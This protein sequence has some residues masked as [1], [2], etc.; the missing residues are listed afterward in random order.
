MQSA[1]LAEWFRAQAPRLNALLAEWAEK[2]AE[3]ENCEGWRGTGSRSCAH[4]FVHECG[5]G[6]PFAKALLRAGHC[7][8]ELPAVRD[9][10]ERGDIS[11]EK[12]RLLSTVATADNQQDW[13][14]QALTAS[15][16]QLARQTR[17]ARSPYT[18]PEADRLHRSLRY[19]H[20]W[21][22]EIGMLRISG[23][24][25]REEGW[26]VKEVIDRHSDA[27]REQRRHAVAVDLDPADDI[28]GA[29]RADALV[30]ICPAAMGGGGEDRPPVPVQMLVH[31]DLD[32]LTGENP[33][34]RGH[35]DNGPALSLEML[36]TL[37]CDAGVKAIVER[38]GVEVEATRTRRIVSDPL[39][40]KVQSRD[41]TCVFPGCARPA[42]ATH[43]HHVTHWRNGGPTVLWNLASL[44]SADHNA[45]HRR[46]YTIHRTEAGDLVFIRRR[47]GRV[48][49]TATGGWWKRPST[50]ETQRAGP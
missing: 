7:A 12:V 49:G 2:A 18:D 26:V 13:V 23:S 42:S 48:L 44:C 33:S 35:L 32:V 50:S 10:F 36:E 20:L 34:G 8:E 43:A 31:V 39:R 11:L 30:E 16:P 37:G 46:E 22:D 14:D 5:L 25:P 9:A 28:L 6:R 40:R 45:H 19:L 3:F 38:D 15:P 17:E 27:L 47:D 21:N 41:R 29:H 4:W 24:L 1:E